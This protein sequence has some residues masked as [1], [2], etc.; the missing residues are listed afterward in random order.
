M[1][2]CQAAAL[3]YQSRAACQCQQK[4]NIQR[5]S[6]FLARAIRRSASPENPYRATD[7][8]IWKSPYDGQTPFFAMRC[9]RKLEGRRWDEQS[10]WKPMAITAIANDSLQRGNRQRCPSWRRP[11]TAPVIWLY[12]R[13]CIL[14]YNRQQANQGF[15]LDEILNRIPSTRWSE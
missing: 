2:L 8:K 14:V 6:F 1:I 5:S 3:Y 10:H 7:V 4:S 13:Y 9:T 12:G 15:L 11:N